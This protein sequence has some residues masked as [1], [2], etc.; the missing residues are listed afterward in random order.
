[1]KSTLSANLAALAAVAT[2]DITFQT[3]ASDDC[4]GECGWRIQG[5]RDGGGDGGTCW[6][7]VLLSGRVVK[8]LAGCLSSTSA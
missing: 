3:F 5:Y 8:D 7:A 6:V 4:T 2:A 1:M